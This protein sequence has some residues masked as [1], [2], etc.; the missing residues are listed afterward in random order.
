MGGLSETWVMAGGRQ[1][2]VCAC[3]VVISFKMLI[4]LSR[5]GVGYHRV[6]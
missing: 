2:R 6:S 1:A 5:H 4:S 3:S